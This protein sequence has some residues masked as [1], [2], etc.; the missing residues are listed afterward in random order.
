MH[1]GARDTDTPLQTGPP[2]RE[3]R[4]RPSRHLIPAA[5]VQ[6]TRLLNWRT[7]SSWI[8]VHQIVAADAQC[9]HEFGV[10]FVVR[11]SMNPRRMLA[12]KRTDIFSYYLPLRTLSYIHVVGDTPFG[13]SIL[14]VSFLC[15][16][17]LA[18]ANALHTEV[19]VSH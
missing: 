11:S 12:E 14:S 1:C 9:L 13:L 19:R 4:S 10:Q 18:Y 8:P 6:P 5:P 15:A 17:L 2:M 7:Q 3:P 16:G